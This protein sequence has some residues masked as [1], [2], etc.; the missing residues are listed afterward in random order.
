MATEMQRA[1]AR[2]GCVWHAHLQWLAAVA[3][4]MRTRASAQR[5]AL[6]PLCFVLTRFFGCT[7]AEAAATSAAMSVRRRRT[8]ESPSSGSVGKSKMKKNIEKKK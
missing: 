4:G 2:G 8:D 1:T 5:P 6:H 7:C 3:S